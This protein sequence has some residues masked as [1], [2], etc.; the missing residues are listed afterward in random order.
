M[1]ETDAARARIVAR[2]SIAMYLQLPEPATYVNSWRRLGFAEEDFSDGG[3]DRLVD[4][5]VAWGDEAAISSRCPGALRR[6]R[7]SCV[8]AGLHRRRAAELPARRMAST[9]I[10]PG[11]SRTK[12]TI[13]GRR[14]PTP[15][16]PICAATGSCR[17]SVSVQS[18]PAGQDLDAAT[19]LATQRLSESRCAMVVSRGKRW[20][21][22]KARDR[23]PCGLKRPDLP[24]LE[25]RAP[26]P[27]L[28][29]MG[30]EQKL[31][32]RTPGLTSSRPTTLCERGD[33]NSH[34]SGDQDLNPVAESPPILTRRESAGQ[35]PQSSISIQPSLHPFVLDF[36]PF[37]RRILEEPEQR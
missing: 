2:E 3:S 25:S 13:Q 11:G 27:A 36:H 12:L 24:R 35:G 34:P 22:S 5:V 7:R 26:I 19:Q 28:G 6:W 21:W 4:H 37:L 29:L 17:P 30:P 23:D 16:L 20:Y 33:S 18:R 9:R 32:S 31:G 15:L 8:R 10:S 14:Q 1:L